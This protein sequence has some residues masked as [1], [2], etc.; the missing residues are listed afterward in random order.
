MIQSRLSSIGLDTTYV[1]HRFLD[2]ALVLGK[3][4]ETI[5]FEDWISISG[6]SLLLTKTNIPLSE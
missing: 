5:Q 2:K 1:I 3:L 4:N 6:D